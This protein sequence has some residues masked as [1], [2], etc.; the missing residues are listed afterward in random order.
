MR[1]SPSRILMVLLLTV[2]QTVF[3]LSAS[4]RSNDFD[5]V[6]RKIEECVKEASGHWPEEWRAEYV[7]AIREIV[8]DHE[9]T[10][11]FDQRLERLDMAFAEYWKHAVRP[12]SQRRD[13]EVNKAQIRWY[14]TSMMETKLPSPEDLATVRSQLEELLTYGTHS[15]EEEFPFVSR[16]AIEAAL[17]DN[18]VILRRMINGG[19]TPALR[20]PVTENQMEQM[21]GHWN[22]GH[23]MRCEWWKQMRYSLH[24][25]AGETA[26]VD[27]GHNVYYAFVQRCLAMLMNEI[28]QTSVSPPEYFLRAVRHQ[29]EESV[30]RMRAAR[31]I[32]TRE[33]Q[34]WPGYNTSLEQVEQWGFALAALLATRT[35]APPEAIQAAPEIGDPNHAVGVTEGDDAAHLPAILSARAVRSFLIVSRSGVCHPQ[36]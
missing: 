8:Q 18:H 24:G 35:L 3:C 12:T 13:Y 15:L 25:T 7:S 31:D 4:P 30:T 26:T 29:Q 34:M 9:G 23:R 21:K 28:W 14:V 6:M 5:L 33:K 2:V 11:D 27:S 22:R 20:E 17:R 10:D 32:L 1:S 19:F 36:M 16:V